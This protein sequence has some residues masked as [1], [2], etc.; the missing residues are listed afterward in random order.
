MAT[1]NTSRMPEIEEQLAKRQMAEGNR[2]PKRRKSSH[3]NEYSW[4]SETKTREGWSRFSGVRR[5]KRFTLVCHWFYLLN[6]TQFQVQL[7]SRSRCTES[8]LDSSWLSF[9]SFFPSKMSILSHSKSRDFD[10]VAKPTTSHGEATDSFLGTFTWSRRLYY[11]YRS[12][13]DVNATSVTLAKCACTHY[14]RLPP[15][16]ICI[17]NQNSLPG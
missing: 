11:T 12:R 3:V 13:D 5:I 4:A 14:L 2:L 9:F 15:R 8:C 10:D 7:P 6:A 16:C 1:R 17:W